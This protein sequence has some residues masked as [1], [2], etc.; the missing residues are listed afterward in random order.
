MLRLNQSC[1]KVGEGIF[2]DM[3]Y[4]IFRIREVVYRNTSLQLTKYQKLRNGAAQLP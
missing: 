2:F 1:V 3:I 4:M